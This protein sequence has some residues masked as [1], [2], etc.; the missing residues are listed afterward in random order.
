[1]NST[2]PENQPIDFSTSL[3]RDDALT[4]RTGARSSRS[5]SSRCVAHQF[6]PSQQPRH[7][8]KLPHLCG[9]SKQ[10]PLHTILPHPG[11][12]PADSRPSS[13]PASLYAFSSLMPPSS[14]SLNFLRRGVAWLFVSLR[15]SAA[16]RG[17]GAG[18]A[19][20]VGENESRGVGGY[21]GGAAAHVREQMVHVGA[22]HLHAYVSDNIE[23]RS[24]AV[25]TQRTSR[26]GER[27]QI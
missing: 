16:R 7:R 5:K 12:H 8:P 23:V 13:P 11:V 18:V 26:T 22:L 21:E 1:M 15:L 6:K 27:V 9:S 24:W 2:W 19:G 4:A 14:P 17:E 3:D 20:G 10:H 25:R